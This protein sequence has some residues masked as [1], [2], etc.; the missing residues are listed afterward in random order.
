MQKDFQIGQSNELI[1]DGVLYDLHNLYDFGGIF[2]D[3]SRCVHISFMPNVVHGKGQHPII[4]EFD[5]VDYL[6]FSQGFGMRPITELDEMGYKSP[7][8]RDD[9]WLMTEEQAGADDHL[10]FRLGLGDDF[11]RVHSRRARLS[12]REG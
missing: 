9:K 11:V 1:K 10:F 5:E 4:V 12:E 7:G 6:E 2:V 8:D 3:G